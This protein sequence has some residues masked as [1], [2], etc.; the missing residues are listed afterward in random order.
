VPAGDTPDARHL[1]VSRYPEIADGEPVVA[2]TRVTVR[3]IV[4]YDAMYHD[5]ERTL[6]AIPLLT[7]DQINDALAY[8][9]D[10]E[11]EI[12]AYISANTRAY[13]DGARSGIGTYATCA[14]EI[15]RSNLR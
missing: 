11:L 8:Y 9:H 1:L 4:E 15:A 5:V 2:G 7:R 13:D 6:R 10:H 14:A 3:S 12:D